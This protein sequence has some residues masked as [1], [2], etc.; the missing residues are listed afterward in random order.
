MLLDE[1]EKAHAEVHKRFLT[2]WND[3]FVTEAS[4]GDK[5]STETCIFIL[6]T[7]AASRELQE[8]TER[9]ADMSSDASQRAFKTA[10]RNAGFAPEVLSRIDEVFC[11]APLAPR[12]VAMIVGL[13]LADLVSRYKVDL[14]P[15]GID[16][17]ILIDAVRRHADLGA[18]GARE[19]ARAIEKE[20]ADAIIDA[21]QEGAKSVRLEKSAT[22]R[23][24]AV[25]VER[26]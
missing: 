25:T 4:N 3:G 6:T 21:R 19:I 15:G 1:F 17:Q 14:A 12:S 22:G 16:P 5:V 9:D 26:E 24:V 13:E 23:I 20:A 10:L 8:I 2:A 11:F 7:N 18:A